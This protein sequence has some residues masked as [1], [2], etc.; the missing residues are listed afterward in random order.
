VEEA[1]GVGQEVGFGVEGDELVVRR[2]V[3][4]AGFDGL[5]MGY[6]WFGAAWDRL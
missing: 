4:V 3:G 2:A 1:E 6:A 5:R